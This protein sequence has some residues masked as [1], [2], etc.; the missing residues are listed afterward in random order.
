MI[1]HPPLQ[2]ASVWVLPEA[3]LNAIVND[4][5]IIGAID[6]EEGSSRR[7]IRL[8]PKQLKLY[9]NSL[10]NTNITYSTDELR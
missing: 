10:K 8:N 6:K 7:K 3:E 2:I 5:V 4:L 9:V 1:T